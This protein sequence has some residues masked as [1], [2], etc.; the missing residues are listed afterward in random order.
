MTRGDATFEEEAFVFRIEDG[1]L[2]VLAGERLHG[3]D[4]VPEREHHEL[5]AVADVAAE[6]PHALVSRRLRVAGDP[7]FAHVLRVGISICPPHG[8]SPGA[9]DHPASSLIAA[10]TSSTSCS[11]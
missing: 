4:R 9:S 2:V 3:L 11:V 5:R 8:P 6:H 10:T 7:R 1:G